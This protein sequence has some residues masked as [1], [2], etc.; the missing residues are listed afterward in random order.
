MSSDP[1][2][3]AVFKFHPAR[4]TYEA[5]EIDLGTSTSR[6]WQFALFTP[7][8]SIDSGAIRPSRYSRQDTLG[9]RKN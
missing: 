2:A 6:P 8:Y 5:I 4:G 7:R 3:T 9:L 1:L